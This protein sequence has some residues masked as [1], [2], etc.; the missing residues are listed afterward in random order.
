MQV[1]HFVESASLNTRA[2]INKSKHRSVW[3]FCM[4]LRHDAET[5]LHVCIIPC[6]VYNMQ[7]HSFYLVLRPKHSQSSVLYPSV[8]CQVLVLLLNTVPTSRRQRPNETSQPWSN[9]KPSG[10]GGCTFDVMWCCMWDA[11]SAASFAG[12][13]DPA[14]IRLKAVHMY[15]GVCHATGGPALECACFLEGPV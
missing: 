5:C 4:R 2:T 14:S 13:I 8:P 6:M 11:C 15:T 12:S 9:G 7:Q 3:Q 1:H 10:S